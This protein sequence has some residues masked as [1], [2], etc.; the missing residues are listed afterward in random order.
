MYK[1]FILLNLKLRLFF[2]ANKPNTHFVY[3]INNKHKANIADSILSTE[4]ESL[5][6]RWISVSVTCNIH[7]SSIG[8]F[9]QY[10]F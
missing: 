7:K 9:L 6:K 4:D 1:S 3:T 8:F 10:L 5:F 2:T